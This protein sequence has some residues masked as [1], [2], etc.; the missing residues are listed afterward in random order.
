M[1]VDPGGV[2][3]DPDPNLEK[4]GSYNFSSSLDINVDTID[5]FGIYQDCC[6]T[7]WS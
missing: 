3:P 2:D 1:Q 5:L 7:G 6:K 4:P